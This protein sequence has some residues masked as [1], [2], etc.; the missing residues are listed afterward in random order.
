MRGED[1]P[2]THHGEQIAVTTLTMARLQERI[3]AQ[4]ALALEPTT[5]T[6]A[7]MI[8]RFGPELGRSCWEAFRPKGLD[9]EMT[10]AV[11]RR[12]AASWPSIS[13]QLRAVGRPARE[14]SAALRAA[15]APTS[16]G[17]LGITNGF[18]GEAVARGTADPRPLHHARRCRRLR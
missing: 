14:L 5:D 4:P 3:L 15:G 11:N 18:Y 10:D 1:L 17:D 16:P 2:M 7:T 12:L 6:A 13:R 8:A 9:A